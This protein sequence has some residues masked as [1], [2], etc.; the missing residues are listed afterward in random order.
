MTS[1]VKKKGRTRHHKA[2]YTVDPCAGLAAGGKSQRKEAK[3]ETLD[4]SCCSL[5]QRN[6]KPQTRR[7]PQANATKK[8][9]TVR[10]KTQGMLCEETGK[11]SP[12]KQMSNH[13]KAGTFLNPVKATARTSSS[14]GQIETQEPRPTYPGRR[15][16]KNAK[17][18][19][20][21]L[22]TQLSSPVSKGAAFYPAAARRNRFHPTRVGPRFQPRTQSGGE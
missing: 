22:L 14:S 4:F 7:N 3:T 19:E 1:R 5:G 11:A 20:S 9:Q 12:R 13:R 10:C 17:D 6:Q 16:K 15:R 18:W 2:Y 21:L 8:N